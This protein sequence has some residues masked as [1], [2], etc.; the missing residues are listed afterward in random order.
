[1]IEGRIGY[2]VKFYPA[3]YLLKERR[4]PDGQ[5]VY[6][7]IYEQHTKREVA[8]AMNENDAKQVVLGLD[9]LTAVLHGDTASQLE[10][11]NALAKLRN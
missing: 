5:Y 7:V 2:T 10:F 8:F 1:M 6:W 11:A 9:H 3:R 4:D